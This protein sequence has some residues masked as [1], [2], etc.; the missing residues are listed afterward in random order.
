MMIRDFLRSLRDAWHP[1]RRG[2]GNNNS[3]VIRSKTR[4]GFTL[5]LDGN[6]NEVIIGEN[7]LL[8]NTAICV[9]G[10]NNRIV[11]HDNVRF[12]GPC[13]AVLEGN[14]ELVVREDAGIR[15]VAFL[16]HGAKI[17][18]GERCMFSYGI[19]LRNHDSH[20]ILDPDTGCVLNPPKDIVL[21]PHVWVAQNA[22][23]LKGSHIGEDSVIGFGAVV[24]K[25]CPPGSV[26]T[27]V[28]AKVV[29][30]NINWDY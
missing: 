24:T 8:T 25:D 29:K 13:H 2:K 28:P 15:G 30:E 9:R 20:R 27:G 26:M 5:V 3:I 17:D 16:L 14:S 18:I 23:I 10:D 22:T 12:M 6:N 4:K 7:C 1:I 11:I 21:G 19:T